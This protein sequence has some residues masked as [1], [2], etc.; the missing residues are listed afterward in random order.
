V[1]TANVA[2]WALVAAIALAGCAR[3]P[4]PAEQNAQTAAGLAELRR[5][6][7]TLN[8]LEADERARRRPHGRSDSRPRRAQREEPAD[9]CWQDYC[10]CEQPQ[11]GPDEFLCRRLRAGLPVDDEQMSIGAGMRD[12]RR[13]IRDFEATNP[14]Y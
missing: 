9:L 8:R 3:Q 4:S 14:A 13:Q 12:A 7:D 1:K 11:G 5:L 6:S 10:P 2:H